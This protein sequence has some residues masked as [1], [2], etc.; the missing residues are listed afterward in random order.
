M[1]TTV[2]TSILFMF[3]AAA[4]NAQNTERNVSVPDAVPACMDRNGPDCLLKSETVSPRIGPPPL[5]VVPPATPTTPAEVSGAIA[6]TPT[7]PRSGLVGS[8]NTI[9]VTP[10]T[11]SNSTSSGFTTNPNSI[12]GNLQSSGGTTGNSTSSGFTTNPGSV[13]GALQSGPASTPATNTTGA[14][15]VRR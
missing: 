5:V 12:G 8:S 11:G 6:P 14:G 9:V 3:A 10:S 4:A 7:A 2:A 1:K 13:G 15:S